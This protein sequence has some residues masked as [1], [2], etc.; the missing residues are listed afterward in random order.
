MMKI[1]TNEVEARTVSRLTADVGF[2]VLFPAVERRGFTLI[3]LLVV[4]G[5]I[6]I[7][8]SLLLPVLGKA[9]SAARTTVCRSNM[10]QIRFAYEIY[11][12]THGMGHPAENYMRWIKNGGDFSHPSTLTLENMISASDPNAYWGVA[13]APSKAN[14]RVFRCPEARLADDHHI[15]SGE[16]QYND[17]Y[18][19]DGHVY[20]TYGFNG[21]YQTP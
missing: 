20:I 4:I 10:R 5:I 16:P 7:L 17:G 15:D 21:Y 8:A 18:F 14:N 12:E 1:E 3:E 13:Y 19:K 11:E 6:A 2:S 9:K